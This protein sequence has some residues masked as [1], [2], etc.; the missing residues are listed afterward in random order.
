MDGPVKKVRSATWNRTRPSEPRLYLAITG[1]LSLRARLLADIVVRVKDGDVHAQNLAIPDHSLVAL[2]AD[3]ASPTVLLALHHRADNR[4]FLA[5]V[6]D[7]RKWR[8]AQM[9]D[10]RTGDCLV[11]MRVPPS[12][13]REMD[14]PPYV[15]WRL[16]PYHRHGYPPQVLLT[17]LLDPSEFPRHELSAI[18]SER[19]LW[20]AGSGRPSTGKQ[21]AI[22]D[23]HPPAVLDRLWTALWWYNL[24]RSALAEGADA[25]GEEPARMDFAE[26]VARVGRD[27]LLAALAAG[28]PEPLASALGAGASD[29]AALVRT[30]PPSPVQLKV[31]P[32]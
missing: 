27:N 5:P 21:A 31:D 19:W 28:D 24:L 6:A 2:D 8:T 22:A 30:E 15:L 20:N 10:Q 18:H 4:H 3:V 13:A 16:V 29:L 25:L 1:L 9:L 17:S 32:L 14:L 12:L 23:S 26:A 7:R 11:E